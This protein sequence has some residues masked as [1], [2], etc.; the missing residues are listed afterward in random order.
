M[1]S[2]ELPVTQKLIEQ[3]ECSTGNYGVATED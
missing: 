3:Q 1:R 2:F